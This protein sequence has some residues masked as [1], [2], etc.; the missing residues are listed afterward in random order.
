MKTEMMNRRAGP[1]GVAM[2]VMAVLVMALFGVTQVAEANSAANTTIRN[3]VT[4]NYDDAAGTPLTAVTAYVDI[5]VNLVEATPTLS[6]PADQST[7]PA[8][9]AV[10]SYTIT[11]NANGPDTYDLSEVSLV[12]SAGISGSTS[13]FSVGSIDLGAST[14][15]TSGTITGAGTTAIAVPSD[16]AN[17]GSVNGI[18]AGDTVV[19]NGQVF[20]VASVDDSNG[21]NPGTSTITVNGNGTD[22]NIAV[23]DVI[24]EQGSFTLTVTPGTVT[25]AGNQTITVNI[26]AQDDGPTAAQATDE[27]ITTVSVPTLTVKKYVANIT[28]AVAGAGDTLTVDT[29]GGAGS[30][31]YYTTNVTGKP[32]DVLEYVIEINNAVG[33]GTATD[34]VISDPVSQFTSYVSSTMRLDPGTGTFAALNDDEAGGDGGETDGTTIYIYAGSGGIDGLAG[35][36]NGTGGSLAANLTTYGVFRV[37][38]D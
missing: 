17:D 32:S 14:V 8:T 12:E 29:G 34:V 7:D 19:V 24:G 15:A 23:G 5:T 35:L 20:T 18:A 2:C 16:N 31:T 25:A 11:S 37:T 22:T 36:N 30:T 27:T 26:G 13:A 28:A 33:A 6:A 9:D 1:M 3:T 38:I 10:Y 4:V 21:G